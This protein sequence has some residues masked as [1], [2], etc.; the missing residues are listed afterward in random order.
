MQASDNGRSSD[1]LGGPL[2]AAR[3]QARGRRSRAAQRK[4]GEPPSESV[5]RQTNSEAGESVESRPFVFLFYFDLYLG[6]TQAARLTIIELQ[7][8]IP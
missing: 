5:R 1:L 7:I 3:R 8:T 2:V 4:A 6:E